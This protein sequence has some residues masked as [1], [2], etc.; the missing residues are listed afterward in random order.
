MQKNRINS[1]DI[2]KL[3]KHRKT[4]E[5]HQKTIKPSR[6]WKS[7]KAS[8]ADASHQPAAN[9]KQASRLCDVGRCPV[10]PDRPNVGSYSTKPKVFSKVFN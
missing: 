5:K 2:G 6:F 3:L 9:S 7:F 8:Q 4:F 1:Q 10:R